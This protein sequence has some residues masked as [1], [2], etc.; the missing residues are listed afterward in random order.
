MFQ[1]A[2]RAIARAAPTGSAAVGDRATDD[3]VVGA[4]LDRVA[5]REHAHLIVPVRARRTDARHDETERLAAHL[6]HVAHV[7]AR[8]DDAVESR[9]LRLPRERRGGRE[10]LAA[11][12][13]T[14][15]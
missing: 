5:R 2:S 12:A 14:A 1:R 9:R 4:A 13:T 6:A 3:E 8:H 7:L 15:P 11:D 10:L